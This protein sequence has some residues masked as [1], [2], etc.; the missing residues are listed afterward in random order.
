M[1]RV[2]LPHDAAPGPTKPEV[3]AVS[4]HKLALDRTD[5]V[6]DVGA[7]TGAMT[8]EVARRVERVTAIERDRE[9]V[10]AARKNVA[11][12]DLTAEVEVRWATAPDGLPD[13]ADAMFL[14]G[15]RDFEGV[16]DAAKSMGVDRFV[17]NVAR[18]EVAGRAV[19]AVRERGYL[20]EVLHLQINRGYD[21]AGA[22]GFDAADPVYVIVGRIESATNEDDGDG[23]S[24]E[25]P[26]RAGEGSS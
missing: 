13:R 7:G 26:T 9:R 20:D 12:N 19:E 22:T 21:L 4:V 17:M 3:R 14:G 8:I 6:V 16:L 25:E 15:S 23:D 2:A 5:H 11:A 10:E 1:G 24:D 18:L